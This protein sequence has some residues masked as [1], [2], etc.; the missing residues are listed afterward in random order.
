MFIV[1]NGAILGS[2]D[3]APG[4][5]Q[6]VDPLAQL[7]Q[8]PGPTSVLIQVIRLTCIQ[9]LQQLAL[10]AASDRSLLSNGDA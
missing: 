10:Q 7:T 2:I 4:I 5:G 9:R 3:S 1:W 8:L 6:K